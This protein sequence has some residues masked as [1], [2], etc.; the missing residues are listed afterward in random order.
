MPVAGGLAV[1]P[2]P[3]AAWALLGPAPVTRS[4]WILALLVS[5][6]APFD[7]AQPAGDGLSGDSSLLPTLRASATR[8]GVPAELLAAIAFASSRGSMRGGTPAIDGGRGLLD[9]RAGGTLDEAVRRTGRSVDELTTDASANLEGGAAVLGDLGRRSGADPR[10]A[11]SWR[12]ALVAYGGSET[13]ADEVLATVR[14]GVSM[15]DDDGGTITIAARELVWQSVGAHELAARPDFPDAEWVGPACSYRNASRG[16]ADIREIVIHTCE[17]GFAGCWGWLTGCHDVSAHYV[18]RSSDGHV[19]QAVENQ[20]IAW[21][22]G[23]NNTNTIGIEHEG[24]VGD[25]GRWYTDEMYCGSAE[26]VRWLCDTYGIPCDRQHVYGHAEADDCSDHT[27]PGAGWDWD[28]FMRF[29]NDGCRCRAEPEVC[30]GQDNDCDGQIDEDVLNACGTCGPEPAEACNC[31]DDDCDG[32]VDEGACPDIA[33]GLGAHFPERFAVGTLVRA[34]ASFRNEGSEPWSAEEVVLLARGDA[35]A[36]AVEGE[37][38]AA[39]APAKLPQDVAPGET[40]EVAFAMRAPDDAPLGERRIVLMLGRADGTPLGAPCEGSSMVDVT[41]EMVDLGL[42]SPGFE[43][44]ADAVEGG[45]APPGG[46]VSGCA[47]G[48]GAPG[49]AGGWLLLLAL[50]R[51]RVSQVR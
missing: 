5:C 33:R 3:H 30:D 47:A 6:A 13:F 19:V 16:Q 38:P 27:D 29:V 21:H 20:D 17:G 26:L 18:V 1:P 4:A 25:P 8:E 9:L 22:D 46:L 42:G 48:G 32:E 39:A 2:G 51:R 45:G 50:R 31:Q 37:W 24:F 14:R 40:V 11:G 44:R 7:E 34:T 35:A 23:C 15:R 28:K 12:E 43:V 41:F 49:A 36:F 10:D